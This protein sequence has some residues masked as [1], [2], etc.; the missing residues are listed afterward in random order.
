MAMPAQ[1]G[2]L[3]SVSKRKVSLV[4]IGYVLLVGAFIDLVWKLPTHNFIICNGGS[5]SQICVC[6]LMKL[7]SV[8]SNLIC[9]GIKQRLV[10]LYL[11]KAHR[12]RLKRGL[13]S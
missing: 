1:F 10:A 12:I 7:F 8:N 11:I 2:N 13:S 6:E 9:R 5:W 3:S 4:G